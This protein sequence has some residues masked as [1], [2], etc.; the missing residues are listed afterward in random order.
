MGVYKLELEMDP[1]TG[2][3]YVVSSTGHR[4]RCSWQSMPPQQHT[5]KQT[6]LCRILRGMHFIARQLR[7]HLLA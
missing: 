3:L 2:I 7:P 1:V 4:I 6:R 5:P